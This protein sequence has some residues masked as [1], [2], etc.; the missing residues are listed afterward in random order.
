MTPSPAVVQPDQELIREILDELDL[1]HALDSE[2]DIAISTAE[3]TVFF[4]FGSEGDLFTIRTFY[5]KHYSVDDK[6]MLVTALNEWN[7]DTMWP[8]VYSFTQD[9]GVMRVVGD[10]QLYVGA[11]VTREH[12]TTV[13]AHWVRSALKFHRW[14][15]DRLAFET[16]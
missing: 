12:L 16:D 3:L 13:V 7:A 6:P 1:E 9:S 5:E 15:T 10:S 4:L 2:G 8:K 11:G 14:L